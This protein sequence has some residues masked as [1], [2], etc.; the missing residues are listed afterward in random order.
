MELMALRLVS[1]I[2]SP[3]SPWTR[4]YNFSI[5]CMKTFPKRWLLPSKSRNQEWNW[6]LSDTKAIPATTEDYSTQVVFPWNGGEWGVLS[7]GW[8]WTGGFPWDGGSLILQAPQVK[9]SSALCKEAVTPQKRPSEGWEDDRWLRT[10]LS[11]HLPIRT[12]SRCKL[13]FL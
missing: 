2:F 13:T 3:T 9:T 8:G 6:I 5:L 11:L 4:Y 7:M 10:T 12:C 1:H